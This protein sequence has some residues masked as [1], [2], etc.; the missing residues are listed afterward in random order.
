MHA[1]RSDTAPTHIR[2]PLCLSALCICTRPPSTPHTRTY[3]PDHVHAQHT[4]TH[5]QPAAQR[6]LDT[7]QGSSSAGLPPGGLGPGEAPALLRSTL[8]TPQGRLARRRRMPNWTPHIGCGGREGE[9]G[10][11]RADLYPCAPAATAAAPASK[12][13][14]HRANVMLCAPTPNT[15]DDMSVAANTRD[16]KFDA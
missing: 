6:A 10:P 15:V 2:S 4:C 1:R 5:A 14:P 13:P 8:P 11:R 7:E 12:W 9:G 3:S 16:A